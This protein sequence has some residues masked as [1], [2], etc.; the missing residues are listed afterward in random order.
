M[1]LS[2]HI[3]SDALTVGK[4]Y[5]TCSPIE[6]NGTTHEKSATQYK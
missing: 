2:F 6:T 1:L 5:V 3:N 4:H